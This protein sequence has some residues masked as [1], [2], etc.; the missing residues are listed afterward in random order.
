[1]VKQKMPWAKL[2]N[3]DDEVQKAKP[4]CS[5]A[6]KSL[7]EELQTLQRNSFNGYNSSMKSVYKWCETLPTDLNQNSYIATPAGRELHKALLLKV[8]DNGLNTMA[9]AIKKLEECKNNFTRARD[10]GVTKLRPKVQDDVDRYVSSERD[11]LVL[12]YLLIPVF[13]LVS[14]P[15]AHAQADDIK[16]DLNRDIERNFSDI[17]LWITEA[18]TS[19]TEEIRVFGV[20]SDKIEKTKTSANFFYAHATQGWY[21]KFYETNCELS[22]MCDEF[23]NSVDEN[24]SLEW[25]NFR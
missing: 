11:R 5:N 19:L 3:A 18:K 20:M 6:T 8:L 17:Q 12:P 4:H 10:D 13:G 21:D 24:N 2:K 16:R 1:M 7:V 22:K 14:L 23:I 9:A 15:I 25:F